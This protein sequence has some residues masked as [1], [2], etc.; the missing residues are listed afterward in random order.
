MRTRVRE[1][2][3][4]VPVGGPTK[5][6]FALLKKAAASGNAEAMSLLGHWLLEGYGRR[7]RVLLARS[8]TR[9]LWWLR[10]A[11]A[12]DDADALLNLA[13]C[14]ADG[15]GTKRNRPAAERHYRRA[16]RL[17][18]Y[19]AAFN[20]ATHFR[21]R[22]DR[23]GERRWLMI[24]VQLGD[25]FAPLVLAEIDL[26]GRRRDVATRARRYL[27]RR[28]RSAVEAVR[29]EASSILEHFDR[30]GRRRWAPS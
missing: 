25:L 21:D 24:A 27:Q 4:A 18:N 8:P 30:T 6:F 19:T 5:R 20:L 17:G 23:R 22:G 7:G 2:T 12:L 10:K 14:L 28:K 16:A 11:A 1:P 9:G 26:T 13:D 29:D 15:I 3:V